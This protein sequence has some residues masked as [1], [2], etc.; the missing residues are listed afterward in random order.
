MTTPNEQRGTVT[1]EDRASDRS[2]GVPSSKSRVSSSWSRLRAELQSSPLPPVWL[3]PLLLLIFSV[4]YYSSYALSGL[5]LQGEGGTIG[6]I[7]MRLNAGARPI[8]DTFLGYNLLWFAPIALLFQVFGP[9]YLAIKVFFF[10]LCTVTGQLSYRVLFRATGRPLL[11]LTGAL[12][13][14]LVPGMQFR[15]YMAFLAITNMLAL[16]EAFVFEQATFWH[17]LTWVAASAGFVALT[18][19]FRIDLGTFFSVLLVGG[20]VLNLL[21]G[22][23][24]L[25]PRVWA[26]CGAILLLPAMFALVH[27]PVDWY[28]RARGFEADFW[29]QYGQWWTEIESR[30]VVAI[31]HL[32]PGPATSS[33]GP[34]APPIVAPHPP[35]AAVGA[36]AGDRSTRALPDPDEMLLARRAKQRELAFLLYAPLVSSLSILIVALTLSLNGLLRQNDRQKQAGFFLLL[37]LGSALTLFPQY[38]FFRPD[39]PHL[40]E[41]MAPFVIVLVYCLALTLT[42]IGR[43]HSRQL[44]LAA[45][46]WAL[47][48]CFHLWIYTRYGVNQPWMG[49][50]AIKK[51]GEK[52]V[53]FANQVIAYLP[54]ETRAEYERLYQVITDHSGSSD[55]VVSFPY[56][57]MINFMT[58]RR[59]YRYNLYVDNST[60]PL[61]FD[62]TAIAEIERYK[63]AV[64]A[65][66]DV[67]MNG[68]P[69]SRFSAWA[70]P[71]LEYVQSHY[72][73]GGRFVRTDLYIRPEEGKKDGPGKQ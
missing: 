23:G 59:S 31:Q 20:A 50:I 71:T 8:T 64:V 36:P 37:A 25:K 2:E 21:L 18:Y 58:N 7:A 42:W 35:G 27:W 38:F 70:A 16:L 14:V 1:P 54:G 73:F 48:L 6:V 65:I 15:N 17:R 44:R 46:L 67:A 47:F 9:S 40:S 32:K 4:G 62:R 52:R 10:A 3:F 12:I 56:S 60:R 34:V 41:L 26:T 43:Q 45:A 69:G 39:P 33:A 22:S 49:A 55:Y 68:T 28:A 24:A 5:D 51:P 53:E 57:P 63:P 30:A 66:D 29:A 13:V 19:L 11:S 61:D 72:R